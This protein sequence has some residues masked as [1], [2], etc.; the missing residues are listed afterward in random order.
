MKL[1][2]SI[3][4]LIGFSDDLARLCMPAKHED[5]ALLCNYVIISL[6]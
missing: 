1:F 4:S 3:L 6:G 2:I 5:N